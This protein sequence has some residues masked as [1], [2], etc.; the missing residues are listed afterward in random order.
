MTLTGTRRR[1]DDGGEVV[2]RL[3]PAAG[4]QERQRRHEVEL[5]GPGRHRGPRLGH[6]RRGGAV[7]EREVG[8]HRGPHPAPGEPAPHLGGEG[9][10]HADRGEA[11]VAR[12]LAGRA[13]TWASGRLRGQHG[14]VDEPGQGPRREGRLAERGE[15]G[16]GGGEVTAAPATGPSTT[17]R[18][19]AAAGSSPGSSP[20]S[21]GSRPPASS[22]RA[23]RPR[24]RRWLGTTWPRAFRRLAF[25]L[26]CSAAS[27]VRSRFT[28][29]RRSW[30]WRAADVAGDDGEGHERGEGG[31]LLL[32][33]VDE[34]AG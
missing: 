6:P 14:V 17:G 15:G 18:S 19:G 20:S 1:L 12:L 16:A 8:H 26:G 24:S 33:A 32:G 21:Q 7:A 34:R 4:L 22:S 9:G 3:A 25:R 10:P 27:S 28:R 2:E 5:L 23:R 31:D 13:A 29:A 30:G 11:V